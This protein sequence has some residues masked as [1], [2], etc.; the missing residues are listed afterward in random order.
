MIILRLINN[1]NSQSF[2]LSTLAMQ[3]LENATYYLH[4]SVLGKKSVASCE[5]TEGVRSSADDCVSSS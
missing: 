5:V 2:N 4:R 1:E 3:F